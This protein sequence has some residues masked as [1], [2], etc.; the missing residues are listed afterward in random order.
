MKPKLLAVELWGI[1]DLVVS[2][3]FLRAAADKYELTLLAKSTVQELQPRLWPGVEV[4]P[5]NI[6]WTAFRGKYN[7]A[8]WPWRGLASLKRQLRS[9]H[10]DI[11]VSAR[12][13]PRDHVLLWL[14][15]APRRIGFPRLGSGAFLTES[16]RPPDAS[17]HRYENWRLLGRSLGIDLP[18]KEQLTTA[19]RNSDTI[20]IHTGAAQPTRVW[21]LERFQFLA[22]QLRQNH[23]NVQVACNPDQRAWWA[24][25]AENAAVPAS[26]SELMALIDNAGLFIGNDSGPGHLAAILGVPTFTI[27]GNGLPSLFAPLHPQAEWMEGSACPYKPCYDSCRFAAPNCILSTEAAEAWAKI[28]LFAEK[29]LA[30]NSVLGF[31]MQRGKGAE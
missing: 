6:P 26:L 10:F 4:I 9:R 23:Y 16:L 31:D 13:D 27:F 3:P 2:T 28:K 8:R 17:L 7:L 18:A 20:L 21:P 15:G 11:A 29:H 5:F 25:R 30:K 12:W 1:G 22:A 19:R 24:E 14:A